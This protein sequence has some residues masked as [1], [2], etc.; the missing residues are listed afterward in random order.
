MTEYNKQWQ[1]ILNNHLQH[2]GDVL[3]TAMFSDMPVIG[4][5]QYSKQT[6]RPCNKQLG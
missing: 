4:S 2:V 1:A 5:K 6:T 3:M